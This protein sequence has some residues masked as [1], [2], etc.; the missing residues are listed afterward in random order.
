MHGPAAPPRRLG[1]SWANGESSASRR[2]AG[3]GKRERHRA[4]QGKHSPARPSSNLFPYWAR[5]PCR[6]RKERVPVHQ[7]SSINPLQLSI[8]RRLSARCATVLERCQAFCQSVSPLRM[9]RRLLASAIAR[10]RKRPRPRREPAQRASRPGQPSRLALRRLPPHASV[11]LTDWDAGWPVSQWG[12]QAVWTPC[13]IPVPQV[14]LSP[15]RSRFSA[16]RRLPVREHQGAYLSEIAS[17]EPG[18]PRPQRRCVCTPEPPKLSPGWRTYS[19]A[20][21]ILSQSLN[22]YV[23]PTPGQVVPTRCRCRQALT[24]CSSATIVAS[25]RAPPRRTVLPGASSKPSAG[26]ALATWTVF[27]RNEATRLKK[28][29]GSS[30]AGS[31][32]RPPPPLD[33]VLPGL[34]PDARK[35]WC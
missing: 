19:P 16:C 30:A 29:V 12:P 7:A 13:R 32:G 6:S 27:R 24:L 33:P 35:A 4:G 26:W 28:K 21:H 5:W 25:T 17:A 10:R 2:G 8:F 23:K 3:N 31:A 14:R 15:P 34:P 11:S 22:S 18:V 20:P 1:P 9:R